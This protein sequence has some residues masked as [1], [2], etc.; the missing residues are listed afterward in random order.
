MFTVSEKEYV[1]RSLMFCY[2]IYTLSIIIMSYSYNYPRLEDILYYTC[3]TR[4]WLECMN[5]Y[6]IREEYELDISLL[7][8]HINHVNKLVAVY[9]D[10]D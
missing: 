1:K 5:V 3:L 6:S 7:D 8:R 10:L 4:K 2:P 9:C